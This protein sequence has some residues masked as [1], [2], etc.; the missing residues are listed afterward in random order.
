MIVRE[1]FETMRSRVQILALHIV[2]I[3]A[4]WLLVGS[5]C[6]GVA[7]S[8]MALDASTAITPTPVNSR[9]PDYRATASEAQAQLTSELSAVTWRGKVLEATSQAEKNNLNRS[10]FATEQ[11]FQERSRAAELNL[12]EKEVQARTAYTATL[13]AL[14]AEGTQ[15]ALSATETADAYTFGLLEIERKAAEAQ[16]QAQVEML[17]QNVSASQT[18]QAQVGISYS[19]TTTTAAWQTTRSAPYTAAVETQQLA[20]RLEKMKTGNTLVQVLGWGSL[21]ILQGGLIGYVLV[22]LGI[23]WNREAIQQQIDLG[24]NS[25]FR[26]GN[27]ESLAWNGENYEAIGVSAPVEAQAGRPAR[28][29]PIY[30]L[31]AQA[32]PLPVGETRSKLMEI[33]KKSQ[34]LYGPESN[35]I[36]GYR[37][38][39][40]SG[41]TWSQALELLKGAE[42]QVNSGARGTYLGAGETLEELLYRIEIGEVKL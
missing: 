13:C 1:R 11:A 38:T 7:A 28:P 17:R 33:L 26:G 18:A 6:T 23:K 16:A 5:G 24:K 12:Q 32:G 29:I 4:A 22:V 21:I 19:A 30:G 20:I 40:G 27:G 37:E 31:G 36:A 39:T 2:L 3:L 42:V 8:G 41:D 15:A 34:E 35:R 14:A 9:T 10:I 25:L